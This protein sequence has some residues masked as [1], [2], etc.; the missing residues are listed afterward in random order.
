MKVNPVQSQNFDARDLAASAAASNVAAWGLAERI[1]HAILKNMTPPAKE[2]EPS[3]LG[4]PP[5]LEARR[6][7]YG[8]PDAAFEQD[9][10]YDWIVVHQIPPK[11]QESGNETY[12]GTSILKTQNAKKRDTLESSR[13]IVVSAGLKAL[14]S[15][16]SHGVDIGHIIS[17][18]RV[19]PWIRPTANYEGYEY[20]MIV[21][22]DGDIITSEDLREALRSGK[23]RIVYDEESKQHLFVDASGKKWTPVDAYSDDSY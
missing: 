14:D 12:E 8:I 3:P 19:A 22:K 9:A 4:L 7:K 11:W 20:T 16:R 21:L 13:G 5:L 15:L 17:F 6:H 18:V 1:S 2:G 10:F 23:C